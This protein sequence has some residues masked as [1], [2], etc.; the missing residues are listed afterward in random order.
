MFI[1][2]AIPGIKSILLILG[3]IFLIRII[4]RFMK[5]KAAA[6]Q[7]ER[8]ETIKNY[9]DSTLEKVD[10]KKIEKDEYVDYEEIK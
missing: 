6:Q 4:S 3:V 2:L 1:I 8:N 10:K 5:N 7:K 9:G